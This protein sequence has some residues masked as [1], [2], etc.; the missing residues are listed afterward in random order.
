VVLEGK[1]RVIPHR[2]SVYVYISKL[3]S[4][5]SSFPFGKRENVKVKISGK[6]VI[7]EKE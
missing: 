1:G 4:N 5:D 3:V 2:G 6:R 7:I